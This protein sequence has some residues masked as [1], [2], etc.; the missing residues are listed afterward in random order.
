V[1]WRKETLFSSLLKA[2]GLLAMR[3]GTAAQVMLMW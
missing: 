2:G 1:E 3:I